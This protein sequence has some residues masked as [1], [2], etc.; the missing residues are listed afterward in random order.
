MYEQY[1]LYLIAILIVFMAQAKVQNA[2]HK[3]KQIRNK[4]GLSGAEVARRILD[5]NDL[6]NVSVEVSNRGILSD[7]YDPV[8]HVVR[9][10]PDIFYQNSI[11]SISVAAHEVGHAIQ[12]KEHYGFIALRNRLLPYANIASNFGWITIVIGLLFF[13]SSPII[14]YIGICMLLVVALFQLVTLPVELNASSRALKQLDNANFITKDEYTSCRTMLKAAAY[15]YLAA[16]VSTI[17]QV[18]RVI[19]IARR[20]DD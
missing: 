6:Q 9:L 12:H 18:L 4:R 16:L 14:L 11:A 5:L 8:A 19:L 13:Y 10:S 17:L 15:T 20:R 2:Y 1:Y 3:Y 7:H